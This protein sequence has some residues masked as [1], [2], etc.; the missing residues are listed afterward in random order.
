M[1]T[2]THEIRTPITSIRGYSEIIQGKMARGEMDEIDGYFEAVIRNVDRLE[3]LSND[4]LDMQRIESGRMTVNKARVPVSKILD[5]LRSEMTPILGNKE[6]T[7]E[8]NMPSTKTSIE[9]DELRI[10]QVLI[11]LVQNSSNYSDYGATITIT[12][13]ELEDA[14]KFLVTDTGIGISDIDMSKLFTP[15]P[16]IRVTSARHGSGLGLSIC[17]GIVELHDGEIWAESEGFGMG[18][19]FAFT[20]PR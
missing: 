20:L 19:T 7:L 5:L 3:H 2:A 17:K 18:T 6:Q 9:C 15:F 1:N 14:V 11:N 12:V 10:L 16:D 13:S 8:I 4:L